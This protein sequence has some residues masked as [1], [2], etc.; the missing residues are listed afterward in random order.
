VRADAS[1]RRPI[2]GPGLRE[3]SSCAV[4]I[5]KIL[6]SGLRFGAAKNEV[7]DAFRTAREKVLD[8]AYLEL[9]HACQFSLFHCPF[10]QL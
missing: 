4:V 7:S 10:R 6:C 9:S 5:W 2:L 1:L 3:F 8:F